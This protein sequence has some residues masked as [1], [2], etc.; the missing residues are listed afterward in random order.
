MANA[1]KNQVI[2]WFQPKHKRYCV[3]LQPVHKCYD[4][5]ENVFICF[6]DYQ[7]AFNNIQIDNIWSI[8]IDFAENKWKISE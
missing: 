6:I 5:Q 4:Q 7:K 2:L 3:I 8:N 1:K